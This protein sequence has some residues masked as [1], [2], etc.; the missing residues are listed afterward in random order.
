MNSLLMIRPVRFAYNAQTAVNN[1]FQSHDLDKRTVNKRAQQ[2]FDALVARLRHHDIEVLVLQDTEVPYT[3]DSI[4]PN[5]WISFHEGGR[6][7]LY[8]MFADNRRLE[9]KELVLQRL[10]EIFHVREILDYT[11]YEKDNRFL[12]GTGSFVLDRPNKIAYACR[13]PRT[14]SELF[15]IVCEKLGYEPVL[16]DAF[17][18]QGR[19]IY[20]TNVMMCVADRYVVINMDSIPTEQAKTVADRITATGKHIFNIDHRQMEHFAGNMLQVPNK[21]GVVHL[22]MST[23]AWESLSEGQQQELLSYNPVIHSPLDTIERNGGGSA[24]CMMAE[25][26]LENK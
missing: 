21:R 24:R 8:P 3:P 6:V 11:G 22:I 17:D 1:A 23:Q 18:Q 20:H 14:D 25:V 26:Y 5:N 7:V 16:F 4:F 12:E 19:A 10:H 9:R 13:S 15:A 2:E